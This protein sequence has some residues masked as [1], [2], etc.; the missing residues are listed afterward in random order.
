MLIFFTKLQFNMLR[1]P[2]AFPPF[3]QHLF[4]KY[5]WFNLKLVG[6]L[7]VSICS[8][9]IIPTTYY[10]SV[11]PM[12]MVAPDNSDIFQL[13]NPEPL[14]DYQDDQSNSDSSRVRRVW[15]LNFYHLLF[16]CLLQGHLSGTLSSQKSRMW[17]C[18]FYSHVAKKQLQLFPHRFCEAEKIACS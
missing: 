6:I 7:L 11:Q 12:D 9:A 4:F 14:L 10:Y 16:T 13:K 15:N 2:S 1:M 8:L 17:L 18:R 5:S 3:L